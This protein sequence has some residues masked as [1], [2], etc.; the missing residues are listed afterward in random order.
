MGLESTTYA[1]SQGD[2]DLWLEQLAQT[3]RYTAVEGAG[4]YGSMGTAIS[5][6]ASR[7]ESPTR[8]QLGN[9][10]LKESDAKDGDPVEM[11]KIW[12]IKGFAWPINLGLAAGYNKDTDLSYAAGHLQWT[13]FEGFQ[14]PAIAIRADHSKLYGTR[15][16]QVARS[17]I[18]TVVS[19]GFLRYFEVFGSYGIN[20]T[21]TSVE[22]QRTAGESSVYILAKGENQ[23]RYEKEFQSTT[24]SYGLKVTL[25]PPFVS[26]SGEV[27]RDSLGLNSYTARL[28]VG[29]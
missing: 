27:M 11:P 19:Y 28:Q 24:Q 10:E 18:S 29:I 14:L 13:L 1:E 8:T 16:S 12:F 3:S 23:R 26:A 15:S 21:Q 6:G 22:I 4:S 17:G 20:K 9:E 7:H 2:V 5:V 25:L